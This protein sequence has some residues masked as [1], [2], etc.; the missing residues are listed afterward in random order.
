MLHIIKT[1]SNNNVTGTSIDDR[2]GC[3]VILNVAKRLIKI[4]KSTN[5]TCSFFCSR[6]I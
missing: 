2:A 4:K 6:R 3:A 5:S 1:L